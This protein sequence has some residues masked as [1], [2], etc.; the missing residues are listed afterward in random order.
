GCDE[1]GENLLVDP[2]QPRL[3][4]RQRARQLATE[5]LHALGVNPA[6]LLGGDLR[7][8]DLGDGGEPEAAKDVADAPDREAE[9]DEAEDG[10]HD[11]PSEPIGGGLADTPKHVVYISCLDGCGRRSAK[12]PRGRAS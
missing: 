9:R 6:E 12:M 10:G 5:L 11:D 4:R 3:V 8:P 2:K 1:L 7:R